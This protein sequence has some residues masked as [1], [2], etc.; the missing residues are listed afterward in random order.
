[1]GEYYKENKKYLL[2]LAGI[3]VLNWAF[4]FDARFTAINL[5]WVFINVVKI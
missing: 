1:M 3:I 4:G 2:I 5:L